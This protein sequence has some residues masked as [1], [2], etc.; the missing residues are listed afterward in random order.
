MRKTHPVWTGFLLLV[1]GGVVG[2]LIGLGL[3]LLVAGSLNFNGPVPAA[4]AVLVAVSAFFF[5]LYGYRGIT[6]GLVFQVIGTLVGAFF[7][8]GIRALLGSKSVWGPFFFSEP[9]WVFGAVAGGVAFLFGSCVG[10]GLVE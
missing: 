6:R 7:V 3:D 5:G 1:V 2:Y 4:F 10:S 9:A 8:T